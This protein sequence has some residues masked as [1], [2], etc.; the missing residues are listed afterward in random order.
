MNSG[1][2]NGVAVAVALAIGWEAREVH[3]CASG[4]RALPPEHS[5][6]GALIGVAAFV[7]GAGLTNAVI[8]DEPAS[9]LAGFL[10]AHA[11]VHGYSMWLRHCESKVSPQSVTAAPASTPAPAPRAA[12]IPALRAPTPARGGSSSPRIGAEVQ[13]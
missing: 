6:V 5:D 3:A 1:S 7:A 13:S 9:V 4:K 10:F 2:Y 11:A 8:D 12:P